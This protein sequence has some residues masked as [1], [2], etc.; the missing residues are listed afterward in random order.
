MG[1]GVTLQK[2]PPRHWYLLSRIHLFLPY[3]VAAPVL[4]HRRI[5]LRLT[6]LLAAPSRPKITEFCCLLKIR[7]VTIIACEIDIKFVAY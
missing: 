2:V 4:V 7:E 6:S 5:Y 3:V 1:T